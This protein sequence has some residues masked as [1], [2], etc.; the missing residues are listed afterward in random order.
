MPLLSFLLGQLIFRMEVGCN[1]VV[2]I[3]RLGLFLLGISPGR[4]GVQ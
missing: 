3:T 2:D 4:Q 1:V